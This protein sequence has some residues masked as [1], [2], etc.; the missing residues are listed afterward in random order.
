M[1][2]FNIGDRVR[3]RSYDELPD[4]VRTKATAPLCGKD[5]EIVDIVYSNAKKCLFYTIHIDG[6]DQPSHKLFTEDCLDLVPEES[7]V[8]YRY[9]FAFLEN[10]VVARFIEVAPD[11]T[12]TEIAKGHGHLIHDG[13]LGIAQ[14]A[15]YALKRI[16][17]D[18]AHETEEE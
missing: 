12:E 13:A 4:G 1:T 14:A 3:I 5:G 8:T 2:K 7:P 15:S 18:I 11:G 10:V 16:W 17:L 9:E 6:Y